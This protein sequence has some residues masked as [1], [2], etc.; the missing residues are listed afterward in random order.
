VSAVS[1]SSFSPVSSSSETSSYSQGVDLWFSQ[2]VFSPLRRLNGRY[3][4]EAMSDLCLPDRHYLWGLN[5]DTKIAVG[6]GP[7]TGRPQRLGDGTMFRAQF[8]AATLT[9][10]NQV[11]LGWREAMLSRIRG[12]LTQARAEGVA[13]GLTSVEY[14]LV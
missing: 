2:L 4:V 11:S 6:S 9:L 5:D 1:S 7:A 13:L 12:R 3:L 10:A 8:D 14:K